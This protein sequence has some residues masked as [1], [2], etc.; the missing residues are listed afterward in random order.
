[1]KYDAIVIGFGKGGKT[2]AGAMADRGMRVA[3]VEKSAEMYG[4]TCINVGCIPSKSLI[5][6]SLD[7]AKIPGEF[8]QKAEAYRSAVEKKTALTTMLRGKNYHMLADRENVDVINGTARFLDAHTVEVATEEETLA[9]TGEKIFINTGSYTFIPPISGVKESRYV[10]TSATIMALPELPKHLAIIGG[11]YIGLEF[12]GMYR[13]FGAQVT[14]LEAGPRFLARE[15]PDV[16]DAVK[17]SL[18]DLGISILLNARVEQVEDKAQGATITYLDGEGAKQVL[19]ADAILLA[20]GRRPNTKGLD[21]AAAGVEVDERGAIRVDS[22]LRTT[23][24][25]IWAM[26][27]VKGGLQFTYVSLDDN[28]IVQSALFGDCSYTREKQRNIPTSVFLEPQ[29]SHVGLKE[30]EAKA[31]GLSFQ[32][33]KLAAG[34]IPKARVLDEPTG[35]LKALVENGTG[36][37]LGC[38]LFCANSAEMINTVRLAMQAGLDYTILRDQVFTHPTMSEALNDL[39]AQIH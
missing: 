16:A 3:M 13:R 1:M 21:L 25:N 26:G 38:T 24:E 23:A 5:T 9:L 8:A 36:K 12:A 28:R 2:L 10:Y 19:E 4:G 7:S 17:G 35:L 14:V 37:I 20:A 27:D 11:G 39:F 33:A 32:V 29:L 22:H 18:E 31:K 30:E 6:Q 34:A 15:D